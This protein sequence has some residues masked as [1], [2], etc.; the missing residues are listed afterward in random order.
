MGDDTI[1]GT[2][3]RVRMLVESDAAVGQ[4]VTAPYGSH[5]WTRNQRAGAAAVGR[6]AG[7][8]SAD[9]LA[10]VDLN[11]AP[12]SLVASGPVDRGS[13]VHPDPN[14]PGRHGLVN[15]GLASSGYWAMSPAAAG[16][17]FWGV[18]VAEPPPTSSPAPAPASPASPRP[19]SAPQAPQ[20]PSSPASPRP[21]AAPVAPSLPQHSPPPKPTGNDA[22]ILAAFAVPRP[23]PTPA[24][25]RQQA[26]KEGLVGE[27]YFA[28]RLGW[29]G[30][31]FADS[32]LAPKPHAVRDGQRLWKQTD[33]DAFC[34]ALGK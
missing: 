19:P 11:A 3:Q 27:R 5:G 31:A 14:Q 28:E 25:Q 16:Q 1:N 13:I 33:A 23:P 32:G 2:T 26:Q 20:P 34:K 7:E 29:T 9:G 10:L 8:R 30:T 15:G 12:V 17:R 21:Q 6:V 22:K 18:T 24:E 4:R